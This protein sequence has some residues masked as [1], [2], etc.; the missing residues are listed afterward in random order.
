MKKTAAVTGFLLLIWSSCV[1]AAEYIFQPVRPPDA[2][3]TIVYGINDSGDVVGV[4]ADCSTCEP[5][6]FLYS[7]G[8]YYD[9]EVSGARRLTPFSINGDGD[10]AGTLSTNGGQFGF[11]MDATHTT[12]LDRAVRADGINNKGE[13]VGYWSTATQNMQAYQWRAGKYTALIDARLGSAATGINDQGE[14]TGYYFY[15]LPNGTQ[16]TEG[17]I[18]KNGKLTIVGLLPLGINS[19]G[20]VIGYTGAGNEAAVLE[21]G[22]VTIF[23]VPFPGSDF[24][25]LHAVN[26]K[27]AIV[28]SYM[29]AGLSFGFIA[30]PVAKVAKGNKK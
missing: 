18:L 29:R 16:R 19:N 4:S 13:A 20:V 14:T 9:V 12:I 17:F 5:T 30:T 10:I 1:I 11:V 6:A 24:V 23:R 21:N 8:N 27:G 26:N 3:H 22:I 2:L 7:D 25:Q 28:G 15:D